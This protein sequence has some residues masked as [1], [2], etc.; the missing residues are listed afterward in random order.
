[1]APFMLGWTRTFRRTTLTVPSVGS[2]RAAADAASILLGKGG[3]RNEGQCSEDKHEGEG[4][5]PEVSAVKR[6][7]VHI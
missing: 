5:A 2:P 7:S 1:M 4:Q 6:R 3:K